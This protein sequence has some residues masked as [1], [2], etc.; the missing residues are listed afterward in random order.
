MHGGFYDSYR[1]RAVSVT[2]F[3]NILHL[4][5]IQIKMPFLVLLNWMHT[6]QWFYDSMNAQ[7]AVRPMKLRKLSK[8]MLH[9]I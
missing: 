2:M 9:D 1:K 3:S 4:Q 7:N 6:F 8:E 5:V